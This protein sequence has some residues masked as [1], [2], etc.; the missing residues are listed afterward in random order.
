MG[1]N[2]VTFSPDGMYIAS[3][4]YDHCIQI[5]S[6]DSAQSTNRPLSG[7]DENIRSVALSSDGDTLVSGSDDRSIRIWNTRTCELGLSPLLGHQKAVTSVVIS[8][9]GSLIVSA[10]WDR[11]IRLWDG[12]TGN[13]IGEPFQA[14]E[15]LVNEVSLSPDSQWVASASVDKTVRIW[16]VATGQQS[17]F[18]PLGCKVEVSS[19]TFSPSGQIIA[20]CDS[21]GFV[22]LWQSENGRSVCEPLKAYETIASAARKV[23][24][25]PDETRIACSTYAAIR[26][27]ELVTRQQLLVIELGS[28]VI[29]YSPNGRFIASESSGNCINVWDVGTGMPVATIHGHGDF[30]NSLA[31]TPDGRSIISC[32]RDK[33]IRIWDFDAACSTSSNTAKGP[34]EALSSTQLIDG[35]L[36]GPSD[37]LLLWVPFDYRGHIHVPPC[38]SIIAHYRVVI[39]GESSGLH[40]GEGWTGC[41]VNSGPTDGS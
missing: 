10:S 21:F 18:S 7:H 39:E 30:V 19:V 13:A 25:T 34:V 14:H 22:H 37:E 9:D 36:L 5:W 27:W 38:D 32:S 20:A 26:I 2:S 17:D 28:S 15:G 12:Q 1:V 24:F 8:P 11:T 33:T 31:F 23:R 35:W 16:D 29:A 40:A 3:A 41:W 6:A 4:S